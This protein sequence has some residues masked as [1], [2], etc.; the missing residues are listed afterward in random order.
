MRLT[1]RHLKRIIREEKR[2]LQESFYGPSDA[3]I[4]AREAEPDPSDLMKSKDM[5][6]MGYQP[7]SD[8]DKLEQI[9]DI[10]L[11]YFDLEYESEDFYE[12]MET[13]ATDILRVCK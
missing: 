3:M 11:D 12:I 6:H 5:S 2:K 1:K 8:K 10:I 13:L 7:G 9:T 4:R